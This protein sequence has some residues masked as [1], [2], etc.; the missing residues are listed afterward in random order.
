M[1]KPKLR[2]S[3]KVGG[4]H[5]TYIKSAAITIDIAT[6][7]P[8]VTNI[9][10]GIINMNPKKSGRRGHVKIIDVDGGIL[11]LVLDGPANQEVWIYSKNTAAAKLFI[12]QG[13]RNAQLTIS[14]GNRVHEDS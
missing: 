3:A 6:K 1:S 7:C 13:A 9:I 8:E 10:A 4:K 12:A 5:R 11:L 14:F 2:S